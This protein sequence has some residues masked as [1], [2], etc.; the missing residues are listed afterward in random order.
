MRRCHLVTNP[1]F[2]DLGQVGLRIVHQAKAKTKGANSVGTPLA[3]QDQPT[4]S[5]LKKLPQYMSQVDYARHAGVHAAQVTRWINLQKGTPIPSVM[6]AGK[7]KI[8]VAEADVWRAGY[9]K[10][11]VTAAKIRS[12]Q[13]REV[14]AGQ[15]QFDDSIE[16]QMAQVRL[17]EMQLKVQEQEWRAQ[18]RLG[19]LVARAPMLEAFSG[20]FGQLRG[21]FMELPQALADEIAAETGVEAALVRSVADRLVRLHLSESVEAVKRLA[22]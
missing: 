2:C 20:L 15:A 18:E 14:E 19:L 3:D 22:V 21:R 8:L 7:R 10:P 6:V 5:T 4:A 16:K 11:H 13:R 9:L 1:A 12:A 17:R